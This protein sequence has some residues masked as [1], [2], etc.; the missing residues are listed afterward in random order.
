VATYTFETMTAAD[1][2]A[3]TAADTLT[4]STP[5]ATAS[6][7]TVAF[8]YVPVLDPPSL[9]PRITL[10]FNGVSREFDG[11]ALWRRDRPDPLSRRLHALRGR[12]RE[13]LRPGFGLG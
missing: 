8:D 5:G 3:F 4:F 9:Q 10:T 1:A 2:K 6:M 12:P 7:V 13:R 11:N